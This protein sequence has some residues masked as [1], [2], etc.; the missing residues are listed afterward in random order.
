MTDS[1]ALL[2]KGRSRKGRVELAVRRD[3][4]V[5]N[6]TKDLKTSGRETLG[7]LAVVLARSIDSQ[8][9][10]GAPSTVA[11]LVQ[12]LRA[13]M[14]VLRNGGGDD[15]GG[16]AAFGADMSTPVRHPEVP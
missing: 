9:A 2:P 5:L 16:D 13:V 1:D 10:S 12:E 14:V 11:K 15:G 4:A 8:P 7:E 6:A 3:L